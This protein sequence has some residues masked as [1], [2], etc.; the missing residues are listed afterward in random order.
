MSAARAGLVDGLHVDRAG[1]AGSPLV[2]L[3][4]GSMDR[5]ASFARVNRELRDLPVLRYDRR[6]YGRSHL[7]VEPVGIEGHVADLVTVAGD[8]PIVAVGHSYGGVVA[9]TAAA[10]RPD[11]VRAVVAFEAP[12][13]WRDFHPTGSAAGQAVAT[14][15]TGTPE[16]AAE[17]FLRRM[18]GDDRWE[19]M[20]ASVRERRRREGHALVAESRSLRA[21]APFDPATIAVPVVA[22]LGCR[23]RPHLQQAARQ[24]ALEVPHSELVEI[25]DC[26]HGAH[27]SHPVEFAGLVRRAVEL[28]G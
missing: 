23:S 25:P 5:G 22:G 10:K 17:A 1:P 14:A 3:I 13:P 26:G 15:A 2:V 27:L 21:G 18:V 24:L 6:G 28:A 8:A 11:V 20:P 7:H 19:A 4:H 16:D 9:L 12:M